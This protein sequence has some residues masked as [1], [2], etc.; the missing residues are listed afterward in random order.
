MILLLAAAASAASEPATC[1]FDV[2]APEPCTVSFDVRGDVT[3]LRAQATSSDRKA[4]FV[5]QRQ[6]GWWSGTLDGEAAMGYELNRANVTFSTRALRRTF[7]YYT[8]GGEHGNY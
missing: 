8:A 4:I 1:V 3:E 2:A 6:S 5:G 7:Q